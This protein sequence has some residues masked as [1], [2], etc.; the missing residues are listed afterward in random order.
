MAAF[1]KGKEAATTNNSSNGMSKPTR[2]WALETTRPGWEPGH[3]DV[4]VRVQ[5]QGYMKG[6]TMHSNKLGY[7]DDT[8]KPLSQLGVCE[9][10]RLTHIDG[11]RVT[12]FAT[13]NAKLRIWIANNNFEFLT[14]KPPQI[15]RKWVS[16]GGQPFVRLFTDGGRRSPSWKKGKKLS[17]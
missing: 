11:E 16:F 2:P 1:S 4:K 5:R 14:F 8:S 15:S 7:V 17:L 12:T 13:T 6:L 3:N 10:F 9:G